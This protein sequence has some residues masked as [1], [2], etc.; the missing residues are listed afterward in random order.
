VITNTTFR[1]KYRLVLS[2]IVENYLK[3]GKPISSGFIHQKRILPDSPATIRNI[4][5]KLE[6]MGFLAQPHASSGRVPTDRGLRFY[7]NSLLE[8]APLSLDQITI[9]AQGISGKKDDLNSLL[10]QTSRILAEHSDSLGFVLSPRI[11]KIH[12]HHVRFIKIAENKVMIILVT[13]FNMVLT[14]VVATDVFF[15][16]LELDRV[17]HYINRNYH[18]K[19]LL[20]VRDYLLGE[21]PK[22]KTKFES[23]F[24]KL[25][26]LLRASIL[27]DE[28]D[29][30]IILQGASKLLDKFGLSHIDQ[31]KSLFQNFEEKANLAKLLS[32]FIALDRVKV[33]IG[34]E[35]NLPLISDC[36]L[37][38]SHYGDKSQVLGSLGIIGPKRIPYK[39]I[40]PLVDNVA[41][42]LTQTI[43][44]NQ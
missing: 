1:E 5:F 4:M 9:I 42:K 31:L 30:Q 17:S 25:M 2:T 41:K 35:S 40:I 18:G 23:A 34:S 44:Q 43:S 38:L 24:T 10:H 21:L 15:D 12:F 36:S 37:V 13:S 22:Y 20:F 8:E 26:T 7:V 14:E 33:L 16:Q 3:I 27:Q 39:K 32:D 29:N 6:G 19:N 11:S 28:D